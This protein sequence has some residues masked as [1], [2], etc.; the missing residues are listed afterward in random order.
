MS[1]IF[2]KPGW[3][4]SEFWVSVGVVVV[5]LGLVAWALWR[6]SWEFAAVGGPVMAYAAGAYAKHRAGTK[7]NVADANAQV[8]VAIQ[9]GRTK[10]V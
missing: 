9:G 3:R 1:Q 7:S 8:L 2:L 6:R 5:G 4:T 10:V